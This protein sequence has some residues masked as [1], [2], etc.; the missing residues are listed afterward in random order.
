[1]Q[2]MGC[3]NVEGKRFTCVQKIV[4]STPNTMLLGTSVPSFIMNIHRYEPLPAS[5]A[6]ICISVT[7]NNVHNVS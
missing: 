6:S 2:Y 4:S 7:N 5:Y 1:M 3:I